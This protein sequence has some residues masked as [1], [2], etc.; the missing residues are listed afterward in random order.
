MSELVFRKREVAFKDRKIILE[1]KAIEE[2]FKFGVP[3]YIVCGITGGGKTTLCMDLLYKFSNKCTKIYY[4]TATSP[5]LKDDSISRIPIA[6]RRKP[7]FE[8]INAIWQEIVEAHDSTEV[9]E[10]KLNR[11]FVL[12]RG[13]TEAQ[14]ILKRLNDKRIQLQTDRKAFYISQGRGMND[15]IDMCKHDS[16][17]FYVDTLSKLIL[18]AAATRGTSKLSAEDMNLLSGLVS[19]PPKTLLLLDDVSSELNELKTKR[20]KV[21]YKGTPT[22]VSDAYSSLL[23]DI[24][25]RGRHYNAL[26]CMFIH[27]VD[28]IKDK[29]LISNVIILNKEAA[30]KICMARTFPEDL[31]EVLGAVSPI[32]FSPENKFCFF[33]ISQGEYGVGRADQHLED[34][35]IPL[36]D[37]NNEFVKAVDNICAGIGASEV[38]ETVRVDDGDVSEDDELDQFTLDRPM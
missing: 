1:Q 31:K 20:N 5:S 11:I 24:L 33:S 2:T 19:P 23:M 13:Q 8:N 21:V 14:E 36:S 17:A 6:F 35:P 4:V 37:I 22:A 7:T 38:M 27:T 29:S 32:V 34:E 12:L 28:L 26:I 3:P 15:A 30:N 9:T 10:A 25:T 16:K 18:D